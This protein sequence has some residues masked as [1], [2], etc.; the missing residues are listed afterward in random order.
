M[1]K[2]QDACICMHIM[3]CI[4]LV[5]HIVPSQPH[6]GQIGSNICVKNDPKFLHDLK[7]MGPY[8]LG[9]D[10]GLRYMHPKGT[11]AGFV[12]WA[13]NGHFT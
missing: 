12:F 7:A 9:R 4:Y 13:E 6:L 2:N 3:S 11:F 5:G 10:F 8:F 1:H